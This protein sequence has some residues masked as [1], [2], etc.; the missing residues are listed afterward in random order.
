MDPTA[1]SESHPLLKDIA[2]REGIRLTN[3]DIVARAIVFATSHG[4]QVICL[5]EGGTE[6]SPNLQAQGDCVVQCGGSDLRLC[7][8]ASGVWGGV[9]QV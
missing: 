2:I 1:R 3:P 7:G 8:V 6:G 5:A 4:A 9:G